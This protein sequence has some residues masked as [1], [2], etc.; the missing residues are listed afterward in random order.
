MRTH[1][2]CVEKHTLFTTSF[3]FFS[4]DGED[5]LSKLAPQILTRRNWWS[6]ARCQSTRGSW[7]HF[8]QVSEV[9]H[10]FIFVICLFKYRKNKCVLWRGLVLLLAQ[11]NQCAERR[12]SSRKPILILFLF[13]AVST[14][15]SISPHPTS[16][17]LIWNIVLSELVE[18][19]IQ[20]GMQ[21]YRF[22][23]S[24]K[25][26]KADGSVQLFHVQYWNRY[27]EYLPIPISIR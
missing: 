16:A 10:W 17:N 11:R 6:P 2:R 13:P 3:F 21:R 19:R 8:G 4:T 18:R 9:S 15:P 27:L 14:F 5:K 22:Q 1:G 12:G 20:E 23:R 7:T 24:F 26:S 25:V